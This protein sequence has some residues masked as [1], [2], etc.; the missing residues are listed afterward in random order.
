MTRDLSNLAT[1]RVRRA[2]RHFCAATLCLVAAT[3]LLWTGNASAQTAGRL[4]FLNPGNGD[5]LVGGID[6]SGYFHSAP[7]GTRTTLI[8]TTHLVANNTAIVAYNRATG[9]AELVAID[10]FGSAGFR[11]TGFGVNWN[12]IVPTGGTF[13]TYAGDGN[14]SGQ[15]AAF[16]VKQGGYIDHQI[17][18][19]SLSPWTN[20]VQ[21]D[22]YLIFYNQIT[23]LFDETIF[24]PVSTTLQQNSL[25]V[26]TIP[27]GYGLMA[28]VDD[29]VIL[30]DTTTGAY[31]V[32]SMYFVGN[33]KDFPDRRD[34]GTLEKFYGAILPSAGRVVFYSY[35]S[36]DVLVG[37]LTQSGELV[38]DKK[39]KIP[40]YTDAFTTGSYLCFYN[41][42]NG[43]LAVYSLSTG[44]TLTRHSVQQIGSGYTFTAAAHS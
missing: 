18:A 30:Y 20:I 24:S 44:G 9:Y 29:N 27:T 19:G 31:R 4:F 7:A 36:G 8:G 25:S 6:P 38:S 21:T 2:R 34:S 16:A 14:N 26:A 22:D 5:Y 15:A 35:G 17:W 23:G 3:L 39:T 32:V 13:L 41:A 11:P 43:E 33:G 10:G 37:H 42:E 12:N 28:A 40:I 1:H